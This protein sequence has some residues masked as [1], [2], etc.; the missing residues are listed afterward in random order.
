MSRSEFSKYLII[1]GQQRLTTVC[2]LLCAIRDC[3]DENGSR[4]I[5]EVYLTNRYRDVDD[6]L[7]FVPTHIDRDSF[8]DLVLQH[9]PDGISGSIGEAY[10]FF[11]HKIESGLDLNSESIDVNKFLLTLEHALEVVMINLGDTDDPY[12]IFESLNAKGEPLHQADLVRNY[13][14]MQFRHSL[15]A[16]GDQE[17]VYRE[18]W[19]P[20]EDA[21]GLLATSLQS[22]CA[23]I[24]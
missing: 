20:M 23:I 21:L 13:V 1:D 9:N 6:T 18:Y 5:Q 16:G 3:L 19:K 24:L 15:S 7:K 22:F 14:L 8:R 17:R 4:R 10:K 2:I 12:L 11:K